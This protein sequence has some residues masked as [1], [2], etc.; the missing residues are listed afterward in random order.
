M[1]AEDKRVEYAEDVYSVT[2]E[3]DEKKLKLLCPTM[4]INSRGDTLNRPTISI[5]RMPL[6]M[7]NRTTDPSRNSKQWPTASSP[8]NLH[9]GTAPLTARLI[10]TFSPT[11]N[12]WYLRPSTGPPLLPLSLQAALSRPFLPKNTLS[13]SASTAQTGRTNSPPFRTAA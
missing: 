10:L 5:V 3:K 11:A 8:C 7:S 9:T 1:A 13:T 2:E 6:S 12:L 4:K